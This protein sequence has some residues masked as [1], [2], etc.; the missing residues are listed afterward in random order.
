LSVR[1]T[2]LTDPEETSV[3]R[4]LTWLASGPDGSPAGYAFLRRAVGR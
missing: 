4:R 1:I 2:A 3:G